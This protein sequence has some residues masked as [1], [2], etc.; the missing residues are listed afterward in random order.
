MNKALMFLS[1][2][3]V[4]RLRIGATA[5]IVNSPRIME[6][7][8]GK[9]LYIAFGKVSKQ[10][11]FYYNERGEY[12]EIYQHVF[13]GAK[14]QGIIKI[15]KFDEFDTQTLALSNR[16]QMPISEMRK[17]ANKSKIH[18]GELYVLLFEKYRWFNYPIEKSVYYPGKSSTVGIYDSSKPLKKSRDRQRKRYEYAQKHYNNL[19]DIVYLN[20]AEIL[21]NNY[22]KGY[23]DALDN[24]KNEYTK[25]N[26]KRVKKWEN[27]FGAE[28]FEKLTMG[29][30]DV[31]EMISCFR[32]KYLNEDTVKE[33]DKGKN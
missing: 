11:S 33:L 26:L 14:V 9:P 4:D 23:V 15:S 24:L 5:L 29:Y 32:K 10:K 16:L 22:K 28:N 3:Q 12:R 19:P 18:R 27:F 1:L 2:E 25:A 7:E 13:A 17:A 31:D 20:F 21:L 6:R 30:V 8:D